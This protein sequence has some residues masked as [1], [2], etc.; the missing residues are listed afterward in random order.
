MRGRLCLTPA[1]CLAALAQTPP[2]AADLEQQLADLLDT[3]VTIPISVA[4]TVAMGL[5]E[6]PGI[7]TLV[8]RDEI[9]A[10]GARDLLEI[11]RLVPGFN[12]AADEQGVL[13]LGVRG[14]W[15]TEGKIS[16][17]LDGIEQNE[18]RYSTLFLGGNLPLDQVSRIEIIRGPGS[19]MYGGT[20]ELA[21]VNIITR[22]REM[23]GASADLSWSRSDQA[24]SRRTAGLAY[25]GAS[26]SVA[27]AVTAY[28]S[29]GYRSDRPYQLDAGTSLP[30]AGQAYLNDTA[31][32]A[33]VEYRGF[34]LRAQDDRY[35]VGDYTGTYGPGV[36]SNEFNQRAVEA[37]YLWKLSDTFSLTPRFTRRS[38]Q[39]WYY[40][41]APARDRLVTR[42]T[43][44]VQGAWDPAKT[45]DVTFGLEGFQDEGRTRGAGETWSDGSTRLAY[46]NLAAYA[47]ALWSVSWAKFTVGGRFERHSRAGTSFVPRLGFTGT[48]G[49]NHFKILA[50]QAFRAPVIENLNLNPAARPERTTTF[51]AE[52]GRQFSQ[53]VSA[54]VNLF[55]IRIH[56][57]LVYAATPDGVGTYQNLARTGSRGLESQ[58]TYQGDFGFFTC[59]LSLYG[60]NGNPVPDFAVPQAATYLLGLPRTKVT[61]QASIKVTDDLSF[62]PSLVGDGA[63]YGYG[64]GDASP[65]LYPACT[66]M[67]AFLHYRIQGWKLL[68]SAGV[69]N[70]LDAPQD[71]VG[72]YATAGPPIPGATREF[73]VR[74]GFN[75]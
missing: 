65:R 67:N 37:K 2:P 15:G 52:L 19:A 6:A 58:I 24:T 66:V 68:L 10:S 61:M 21:V 29:L 28:R 63:K 26:G 48:L 38:S 8:T 70:L 57:P 59:T 47:Q 69:L 75:L 60:A 27:Y 9:L 25:G 17:Q 14:N 33:S 32:N 41:S 16:V 1:V 74:V 42:S 12:V 44:A 62:A 22:G 35:R 71:W 45:L 5:R 31:V 49:D 72:G 4:S 64:P 23:G 43:V 20:A 13:S 51:E 36:L 55:D 40:P 39:G 53:H 11:L 50:A 54:S 30:L 46:R 3:P 34:S 7:V 56:D 73:T 18:L